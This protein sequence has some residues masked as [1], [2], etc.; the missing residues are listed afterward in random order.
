[1]P[2]DS[3]QQNQPQE[4]KAFVIREI[5]SSLLDRLSPNAF[6][7]WMTLRKMADAKTGAVRVGTHWYKPREIERKVKMS[8]NTRNEAMAEL[9]AAGLAHRERPRHAILAEERLSGKP[10]KHVVWA[11]AQYFVSP[12]PRSDWLSSIAQGQKPNTGAGSSTAQNKH[13]RPKPRKQRASSTA[14]EE[15]AESNPSTAQSVCSTPFVQQVLQEVPIGL[16]QAV[17]PSGLAV[18]VPVPLYNG[19]DSQGSPATSTALYEGNKKTAS[20]KPTP[21]PDASKDDV[22]AALRSA[23]GDGLSSTELVMRFYGIAYP[24]GDYQSPF[25][26]AKTL[27]LAAIQKLR[28]QGYT[29]CAVGPSSM[30]KRFVLREQ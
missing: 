23:K 3:K 24:N 19:V 20:A 2:D 6:R 13:H 26:E 12:T 16:P 8:R 4:K 30:L 1:L 10:R 28:R 29:I 21:L 7:L 5:D 22:L 14:Q 15:K 9:V 18:S 11:N 17:S 27:C 25:Y